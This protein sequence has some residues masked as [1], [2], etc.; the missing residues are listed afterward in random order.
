MALVF[1][2]VLS[3][4]T[5][6]LLYL[7][8]AS[9]FSTKCFLPW[10]MVLSGRGMVRRN[11][12]GTCLLP[13]EKAYKFKDGSRNYTTGGFPVIWSETWLFVDMSISAICK[14]TCTHAYG[15]PCIF[16]RDTCTFICTIGT[17]T[18]M[19]IYYYTLAF[20]LKALLN[21]LYHTNI[22]ML[23]IFLYAHITD[24]QTIKIHVRLKMNLGLKI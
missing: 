5:H 11:G 6:S 4:K 14:Y 21:K 3:L 2:S 23:F 10:G 17:C 19:N 12:V 13:A 7:S 9:P 15:V 24:I 22:Y 16:H 20:M 1:S 8:F 18:W